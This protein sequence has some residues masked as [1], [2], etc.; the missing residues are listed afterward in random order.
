MIDSNL[1]SAFRF[2]RVPFGNG[3]MHPA[4]GALALAR[5]DVAQGRKRYTGAREPF[6]AFARDFKRDSAFFESVP[7]RFVGFADE[8]A[9]L[10]HAGW[11]TDEFQDSTLR[12]VVYQL[13]GKGRRARYVAGYL[14]SES[15]GTVLDVS[16]IHGGEEGADSPRYDSGAR[17]AALAADG[18]AERAAEREREYQA[19]WQAGSRFA[20]LA[21]AITEA[22]NLRRDYRRAL[23]QIRAQEARARLQ[24]GRERKASGGVPPL[25]LEA[26]RKQIEATR[27]IC[28]EAHKEQEALKEPIYRPQYGAFNEGAGFRVFPDE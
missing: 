22:R 11:F 21:E 28:Q 24:L 8:L 23:K 3:A 26:L 9:R 10:N 25:A 20:E 18:E 27:D 19:A 13:P 12:G 15:G 4:K 2:H 1:I 6:G 5:G 16:T 7:L 14:E 17:D